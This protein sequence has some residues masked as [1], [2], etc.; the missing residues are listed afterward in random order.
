MQ[1]GERRGTQ[2]LPQRRRRQ[3][4]KLDLEVQRVGPVVPFRAMLGR[5]RLNRDP[6]HTQ[7][8]G[9]DRA[10][11]AL[12]GGAILEAVCRQWHAPTV[13]VADRGLRE[14]VLMDLMRQADREA[15]PFCRP[16]A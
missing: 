10:D 14:G 15:D 11:L 2:P 16:G 6:R 8:I 7:R 1:R 9:N 4:V 12:A 5:E 3:P 13:R